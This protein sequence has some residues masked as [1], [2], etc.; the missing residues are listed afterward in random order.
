MHVH[1]LS[2]YDQ[3]PNGSES[4]QLTCYTWPDHSREHLYRDLQ[5]Y[6]CIFED[7]PFNNTVLQ[8]REPLI[9]HLESAHPNVTE[10][11]QTCVFCFDIIGTDKGLFPTHCIRHLEEIS[12]AALPRATEFDAESDTS[13][14]D[15]S[16]SGREGQIRAQYKQVLEKDVT[17]NHMPYEA[18]TVLQPRASFDDS[19]VS[20]PESRSERYLQ[21]TNFMP[22][23]G[24]KGVQFFLYFQ[25]SY[26]IALSQAWMYLI[27]FGSYLIYPELTRLE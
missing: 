16:S 25:S 20:F 7:C 9:R 19:H 12:V 6:T 22:Q 10:E 17:A 24:P 5:P 13:E 23:N 27:M 1:S 3:E 11:S 21:I 4:A 8:E 2:Q 15:I 18:N 26:D 14:D